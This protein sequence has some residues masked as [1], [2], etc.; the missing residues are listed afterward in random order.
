MKKNILFVIVFVTGCAQ[1]QHG[2]MQSVKLI[3]PKDGIYFT[4]CS[5]AVESSL[6]CNQKASDTCKGDYLVIK[7][8]ETLMNGGHRELTF[9]CKK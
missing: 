7:R 1:L 2:Q 6:T 3:S 9:Q 4:T 5:G 8:F